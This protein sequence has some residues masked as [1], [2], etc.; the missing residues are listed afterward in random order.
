MTPSMGMTPLR[1]YIY[2]WQCFVRAYRMARGKKRG[3]GKQRL[4]YAIKTGFGYRWIVDGQF[5]RSAPLPSS[6]AAKEKE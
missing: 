2:G 4:L 5:R 6:P 1:R 3:A